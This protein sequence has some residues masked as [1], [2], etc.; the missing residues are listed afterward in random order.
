M[1]NLAEISFAVV[2]VELAAEKMIA[3][4]EA[5]VAVLDP[6]VVKRIVEGMLVVIAVVEE[7]LVAVVEKMELAVD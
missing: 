7:K 1:E 5:I 3:E 6:V 2:V 4:I